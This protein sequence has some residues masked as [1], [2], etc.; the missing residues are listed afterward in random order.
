MKKWKQTNNEGR[1]K[2]DFKKDDFKT[3]IDYEY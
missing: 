3:T 1:G 2:D